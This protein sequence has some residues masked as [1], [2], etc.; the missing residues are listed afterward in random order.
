MKLKLKKPI[1]VS[2]FFYHEGA[3]ELNEVEKIA[4]SVRYKKSK[5]DFYQPHET[6]H[7]NEFSYAI[8]VFNVSTVCEY[9]YSVLTF[10]WEL[11]TNRQ[12]NDVRTILLIAYTWVL[13]KPAF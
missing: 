9:V 1:F 6:N 12:K 8:S 13:W 4:N 7:T 2:F 11:N 10:A 5:S 3:N